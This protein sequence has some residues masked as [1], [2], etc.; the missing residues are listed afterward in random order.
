MCAEEFAHYRGVRNVEDG[1][2]DD[3]L[4]MKQSGAPGDDSA[5]IVSDEKD[6]SPAKLIGD[7]DD[8]G[9][10]L[11]Q[12]VS[13]HARGFAAEVVAAL[14]GNDDA[15]ARRGQR[16]DLPAPPIPKFWE[17]MEKDDDRAVFGACGD[18]LQADV[19]IFE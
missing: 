6:F 15:K 7:S 18:R 13:C 10:E 2:L 11:R 8:V 14:V 17:A 5:P 4:W 19:A 9:N 1:E 12:S 16:V 3:A